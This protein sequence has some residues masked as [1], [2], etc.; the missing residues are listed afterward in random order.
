MSRRHWVY[1]AVRTVETSYCPLLSLLRGV[2]PSC[3]ILLL[4]S[5]CV[6]L[7]MASWG[8]E[9]KLIDNVL[10]K[11]IFVMCENGVFMMFSAVNM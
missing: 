6:L 2:T 8:T 7:K 4:R 5:E 1:G 3:W 9:Q 10:K 11:Y